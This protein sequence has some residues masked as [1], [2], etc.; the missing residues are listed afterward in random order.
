MKIVKIIDSL[1]IGGAEQLVVTFAQEAIPRGIELVIIP[2]RVKEAAMQARLKELGATV[3]EI[4]GRTLLDPVRLW[5]LY[6]LL[7]REQPDIIHADLTT[8]IILGGIIGQL[9]SIPVVSTLHNTRLK[10]RNPARLWLHERAI[11]QWSQRVIAVG[12]EVADIHRPYLADNQLVVILNAVPEMPTRNSYDPET[13]A[14]LRREILGDHHGPVLINVARLAKAKGH[15]DLV[16]AFYIAR[17]QCPD[18]KLL[19]VGDGVLRETIAARIAELELTEH[20]HLLGFRRNIPQLLAISDLFVMASHWEGL[21]VSVLE[22]MA[23]GVPIVATAVGDLPHVVV[24]STGIIVPPHQPEKL[25]DAILT[26]V[27]NPEQRARYGQ[28]S[29]QHINAHYSAATWVDKHLALYQDAIREANRD[30]A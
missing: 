8:S 4:P 10:S 18:L 26:I 13:L 3:I 29:R 27:K 5:R 2:L 20:I 6:Q 19:I 25:A 15:F 23:S 14:T 22:A 16:E 24:E 12:H 1:K 9:L 21:P 17:Q 30:T 7:R 28:Q 11:R